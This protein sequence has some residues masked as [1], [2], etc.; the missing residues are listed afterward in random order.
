MLLIQGL[1]LLFPFLCC[2]CLSVS[3][4]LGLKVK[5]DVTFNAK[6]ISSKG[7]LGDIQKSSRF[8]LSLSLH[9]LCSHGL[10]PLP[11]RLQIGTCKVSET[12]KKGIT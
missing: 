6:V 1:F 8:Y 2:V 7:T 12:S 11:E 9:K 5:S 10:Y 3:S 4:L